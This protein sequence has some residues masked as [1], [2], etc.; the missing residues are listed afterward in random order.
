MRRK[1]THERFSQSVPRRADLKIGHYLLAI[2]LFGTAA[3]NDGFAEESRGFQIKLAPPLPSDIR[4]EISKDPAAM[5][6]VLPL[7]APQ[8]R[9]PRGTGTPKGTAARIPAVTKMRAAMETVVVGSRE[10]RT[11]GLIRR[12]AP[13]PKAGETPEL[14]QT[15]RLAEPVARAPKA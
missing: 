15:P 11:Q 3:I 8:M 10:S 7:A 5:P 13:A 9:A 14:T 12:G 6:R 1:A 4:T 2:M